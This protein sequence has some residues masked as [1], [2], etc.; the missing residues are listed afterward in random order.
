MAENRDSLPL[1]FLLISYFNGTLDRFRL[2]RCLLDG[3]EKV[4]RLLF[5]EHFLSERQSN[6]IE[7]VSFRN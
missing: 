5:R 2:C 6:R 4:S 3:P 7:P 1:H